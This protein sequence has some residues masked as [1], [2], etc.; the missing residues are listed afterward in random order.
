MPAPVAFYAPLKAPT[1]PNPSGDRLLAR[2]LMGAL[3]EAGFDVRLA[4]T[5]RSR[6]AIGNPA[7]QLRL[8]QLGEAL[9]ARLVHRWQRQQWQPRLWFTYHLYYKAP[10]WIGPAVCRQL[11]IPYVCAEASWAA[12]RASGSWA[13]SHQS[14]GDALKQAQR[15]FTLNP[16]DSEGLTD[17]LG[18]G[19][20]IVR[21][22]PFIDLNAQPVSHEGKA[23]L[24]KRWQLDAGKPWLISVAMMRPGDKLASYRILA[25]SMAQLHSDV[26]LLIVGDGSARTEVEAAFS[27]GLLAPDPRVRFLG[28]LTPAQLTP[29]LQAAD[30][31]VWPAVNEAFGMALL[32]A[33][34]QG[35]PVIAGNERGVC[36]VVHNDQTGQLVPPRDPT[37]LARTLEQA[38]AQPALRQR[39]RDASLVQVRQQ[40]SLQAAAAV[41]RAELEPLLHA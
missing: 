14:V 3:E 6:D 34:A 18:P 23:A 35:L 28:Q 15:I 39:W 36:A 30:L 26:E 1:H 37:A 12:S 20:P 41:L 2:L 16:T 21:L 11:G 13:L 5:L 10:D 25:A 17:L 31:M 24:A 40:H 29:L 9:A 38:L 19:A 22:S 8:A 7:R 4:C 32:E 33:Q 27:Q